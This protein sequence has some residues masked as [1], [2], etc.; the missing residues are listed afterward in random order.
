MQQMQC[1]AGALSE[2]A[3]RMPASLYASGTPRTE[4]AGGKPRPTQRRPWAI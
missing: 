4:I 3:I 2:A 1:S